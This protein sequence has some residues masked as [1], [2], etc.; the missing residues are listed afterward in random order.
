MD[1]L[2]TVRGRSHVSPD[3]HLGIAPRIDATNKETACA[4][5]YEEAVPTVCPHGYAEELRRSLLA[6]GPLPGDHR[7]ASRPNFRLRMNEFGTSR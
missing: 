6:E 2:P 5:A 4:L 3:R 1:V 7:R